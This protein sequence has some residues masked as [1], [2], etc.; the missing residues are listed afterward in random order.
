MRN[1]VREN[2][3]PLSEGNPHKPGS[4]HIAQNR[5]VNDLVDRPAARSKMLGMEKLEVLNTFVCAGPLPFRAFRFSL[6]AC[7]PLS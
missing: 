6:F 2:I 4:S 3:G 5:T 7:S 1:Q